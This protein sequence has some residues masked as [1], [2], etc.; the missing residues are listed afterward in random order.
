MD[1]G[2]LK[3][4]FSKKTSE[5]ASGSTGLFKIG[6][7]DTPS[8]SQKTNQQEEPSIVKQTTETMKNQAQSI[9]DKATGNDAKK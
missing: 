6:D 5:D 8:E 7:Y 1:V 9:M 4:P 2:Q 3:N